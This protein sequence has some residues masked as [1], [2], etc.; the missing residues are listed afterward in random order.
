M[1]NQ[2]KGRHPVTEGV[3][4][5]R[6]LSLYPHFIVKGH[7]VSKG[8]QRSDIAKIRLQPSHK[9]GCK[10]GSDQAIDPH[11]D[12][13]TTSAGGGIRTNGPPTV[14][15]IVGDQ[16]RLNQFNTLRIQSNGKRTALI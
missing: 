3:C 14:D 10:P 4:A 7:P 12:P 6:I 16:R 13:V 5:F 8:F 11:S 15:M 2:N 9:T 1:S